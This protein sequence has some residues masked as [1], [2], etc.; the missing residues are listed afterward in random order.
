MDT[1]FI[2][3]YYGDEGIL[4]RDREKIDGYGSALRSNGSNCVC[5]GKGCNGKRQ[6]LRRRLHREGE[7]CGGDGTHR[8]A[9]TGRNRPD[10]HKSMFSVIWLNIL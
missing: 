5:L 7:R 9:I 10:R 3:C 8:R 2:G 1:F 4:G 6:L